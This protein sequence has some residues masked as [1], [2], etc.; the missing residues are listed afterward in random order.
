M[1]QKAIK[2]Q[3]SVYD[4]GLQPP[5]SSDIWDVM[6]WDLYKNSEQKQKDAWNARSNV[7]KRTFDFTLCDSP[8]L[9][10]EAKYFCFYLLIVKKVSLRTFAEYTDRFKWL[11]KFANSKNITS[12]LDIDIDEYILYLS[13]T[14]HKTIIGNGSMTIGNKIVASRKYNRLIS[15]ASYFRSVVFEYIDSKKTIYER[16]VWKGKEIAIREELEYS[17]LIFTDIVQEQIKKSVKKYMR[18][19]LS[20]VVL[21]SAAHYLSYYRV[22]SKWLYE[23]DENIVSLAQV[24]REILEEYFYFLRVESGFTQHE[25]NNNILHLSCLFEWGLMEEDKNFPSSVLF[26][27]EDYCFKTVHKTD[28]YRDED[29]KIIFN[30]LIPK[31]PKIYGRILLILHHTGM[32][33][34]EVLRLSILAIKLKDGKPYISLY[35]YKTNRFN[36]VPVDNYIYELLTKEVERTRKLH[37]DS[38]YVFTDSNGSHICYGTF[39]KTIK[40]TI[41]KYNI[42]DSKGDLLEFRTHRFRATKATKMINLGMDPREAASMLGQKS[43]S[44]LSYYAVATNQALNEQMQE[45]LRKESLLINSIGQMDKLALEDYADSIPLCNGYCCRPADLGVCPKLNACLT[46]SL[47]KPSTQFLLNYKMQ[48]N[49]LK[50]SLV[51]AE[52]N[53]YTRMIEKCKE[54]IIAL[55]NIIE[56]VEE[57]L[58]EQKT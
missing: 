48:L 12:I 52:A 38:K 53:G 29:L 23:Y 20:N 47:F 14:N 41:V 4:F 42:T 26:L 13:N 19:K 51:V 21:R 6:T 39:I 50:A 56:K 2:Q 5:Y 44:S 3:V 37:P 43:L 35:M 55:E 58:N 10:E 54:D 18:F 17:N 40:T 33:I 25:I 27:S 22:F 30:T 32:R 57:K 11:F 7:M 24:T 8:E 36:D 46:C 45:Y 34:S 1:L 28:F 31:L 16:D 49:D 15:F 9:R